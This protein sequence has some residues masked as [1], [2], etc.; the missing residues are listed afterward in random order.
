VDEVLGTFSTSEPLLKDEAPRDVRTARY[1]AS[2]RPA[3]TGAGFEAR[4]GV[5]SGDGD[6]DRTDLSRTLMRSGLKFSVK[7]QVLG[8]A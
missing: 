6:L 8:D 1:A 4:A 5:V 7:A 2:R 3:G